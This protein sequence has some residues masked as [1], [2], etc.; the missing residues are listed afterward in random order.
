MNR[1][2]HWNVNSTSTL[3][4]AA[5]TS[6]NPNNK[7]DKVHGSFFFVY[8]TICTFH[9]ILFCCCLMFFGCYQ[10]LFLKQSPVFK[11]TK[12]KMLYL[13]FQ[14]LFHRSCT[15]SFATYSQGAMKKLCHLNNIHELEQCNH[16]ILREFTRDDQS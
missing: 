14:A 12:Y 11:K 6:T 3:L 7:D 4:S 8:I 5:D 10:I 2:G 15:D 9:Q 13:E 1:Y 16:N